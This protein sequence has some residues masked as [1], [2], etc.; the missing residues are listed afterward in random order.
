M[1]NKYLDQL[2][3]ALLPGHCICCALPSARQLD[4]CIH[5]E[6]MFSPLAAHCTRCALPLPELSPAS[7]APDALCAHCMQQPP[8][9]QHCFAPWPYQP[10]LSRLITAF[11]YRRHYSSGRVL[12]S[13]LAQALRQHYRNRTMPELL[14]AAPMHWRRLLWRGFNHSDWLARHLAGALQQ[15]NRQLLRRV[16]HTATQQGLNARQR[17]HN[18]DQAFV[19]CGDIKGHSI[20]V[21]DDVMTT[22]ATANAISAALLHAGAR[23]IHIWCLART[24]SPGDP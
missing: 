13:L 16:R 11:K 12:G 22:G 9:F 6:S 17:E 15:P 4:L 8:L 10:P 5:C 1:V 7:S 3:Y 2:E 23:E 21:V 14:T 24:A 20:A 19:A 18:L